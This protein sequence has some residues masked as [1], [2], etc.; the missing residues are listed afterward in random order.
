MRRPTSSGS[1][2]RR[3]ISTSGSSGRLRAP[4]APALGQD[5]VRRDLVEDLVHPEDA[6]P[7]VA[8]ADRRLAHE[9]PDRPLRGVLPL[10]DVELR[11]ARID[12]LLVVEAVLRGLRV[13]G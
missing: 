5:L 4:F 7:L 2:C 6:D 8:D 9:D 1:I 10:E 3:V 11:L 12:D 13:P